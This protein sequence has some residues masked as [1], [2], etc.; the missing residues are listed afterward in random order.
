MPFEYE[1]QAESEIMA[2]VRQLST[3]TVLL[4]VR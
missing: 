1:P 3:G 2:V 4:I